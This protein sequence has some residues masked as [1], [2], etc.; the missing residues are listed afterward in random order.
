MFLRRYLEYPG[1]K[2]PGLLFL[3]LMC[4][5]AVVLVEVLV[6]IKSGSEARVAESVANVRR[7][8]HVKIQEKSYAKGAASSVDSNNIKDLFEDSVREQGA[9]FKIENNE[10]IDEILKLEINGNGE[11]I[12]E[13]N[14]II[15]T[16]AAFSTE[17]SRV[18]SEDHLNS[19][20]PTVQCNSENATDDLF[21]I[22]RQVRQAR[23]SMKSAVYFSK[24]PIK[25]IVISNSETVFPK[26]QALVQS[27]PEE[28][29]RKITLEFAPSFYPEKYK[30]MQEM[31]RPCST[32]RLFLEQVLPNEDAIL[33]IDTD[34]IFMRSPGDAWDLFEK[35]GKHQMIA[36]AGPSFMFIQRASD[37]DMKKFFEF[38]GRG[39][40]AGILLFN[41]TRIRNSPHVWEFQIL[42]SSKLIYF[43]QIMD[44]DILNFMCN[45]YP[46]Y[47]FKLDCE[48]NFRWSFC[49]NFTDRCPNIL[50]NGPSIV[51]G[52]GG[53]F[54]N[55]KH[56][57]MVRMYEEFDK[58]NMS[59]PVSTLINT[60]QTILPNTTARTGHCSKVPG[61]D[62]ALLK[63]LVIS[64]NKV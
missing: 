19:P 59:E 25:L 1:R 37:P 35:F 44:Q 58:W 53:A 39:F 45:Q 11:T 2:T 51:H 38:E 21:G 31:F 6:Y 14:N 34:V 46:N 13:G 15:N 17:E 23:V 9:L 63:Q 42:V 16:S 28:Q 29:S 61:I 41:L 10:N 26:I 56:P 32:Q 47:C 54:A 3:A 8:N 24:D 49:A 40:N 20:S 43:D 60:L 7:L 55:P 57:K 12:S 62:E 48:W 36:A 27:W 64:G 4:I 33:Y 52:I 50:K 5:G 18:S 22:E 30:M